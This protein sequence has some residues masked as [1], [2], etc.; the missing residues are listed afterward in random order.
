MYDLKQHVSV[1]RSSD[2]SFGYTFSIF[3]LILSFL[4]LIYSNKINIYLLFISVLFLIITISFTRLLKLP[5]KIWLKFGEILS[6]ITSPIIMFLIF[7]TA[8]LPTKIILM[9]FNKKLLNDKINKNK[10]TYWTSYQKNK[11]NMKD[12]F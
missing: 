10:K 6:Y 2:K 12:Q 7:V 9:I 1:K 11:G 5:N 3:F 4:P 8:F